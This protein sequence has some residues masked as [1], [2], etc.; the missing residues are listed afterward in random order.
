MERGEEREQ[1]RA[2]RRTSPFLLVCFPPL[3]PSSFLSHEGEER[4]REQKKVKRRRE[5][6]GKGIGGDDPTGYVITSLFYWLDSLLSLSLFLHH[7]R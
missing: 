6:N 7:E 3:S 5:G 1:R 2:S 4:R